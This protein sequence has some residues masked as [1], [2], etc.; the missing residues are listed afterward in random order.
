MLSE[1]F[2]AHLSPCVRASCPVEGAA[3]KRT[4]S[5]LVLCT[6]S[7][8][9]PRAPWA[10]SM[11][12]L[13]GVS[14]IR[15]YTYIDP[16]SSALRIGSCPDDEAA[17]GL[18]AL[19]QAP[20]WQRLPPG[21][22]CHARAHAMVAASP[23]GVAP[24]LWRWCGWMPWVRG[25]APCRGSGLRFGPPAPHLVPLPSGAN[26]AGLAVTGDTIAADPCG[27]TAVE[28]I[29]D[30]GSASTSACHPR[31]IAPVMQLDH[32][33][34]HAWFARHPPVT[35]DSVGASNVVK[36]C[37]RWMAARA[38]IQPR[39][40]RA[41]VRSIVRNSRCALL[42][43]LVL[44]ACSLGR[45]ETRFPLADRVAQGIIKGAKSCECGSC[46]LA[47]VGAGAGWL[48]GGSLVSWSARNASRHRGISPCPVLSHRIASHRIAWS[49]G[50]RAECAMR[51][52][53]AFLE[54]A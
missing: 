25:R 33:P 44:V 8:L 9:A 53:L 2:I 17:S 1:Y 42:R 27:T 32:H 12:L 31:C 34:S 14:S 46:V 13:S 47:V 54:L 18:L 11:E 19:R 15:P 20:P 26:S 30:R 3:P 41:A 6:C 40:V 38:E 29:C 23:L 21:V 52:L 7:W 22:P 39:P 10:L 48:H 16:A 49:D 4:A 45:G 50:C 35:D 5:L 28:Q 43:K 37:Q 51:R 24:P 36:T